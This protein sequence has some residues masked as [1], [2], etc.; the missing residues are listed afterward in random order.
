MATGASA[1]RHAQA[2]FQIA[3]ERDEL[4]IWLD[5]LGQLADAFGDPEFSRVLESPKIRP[6]QKLDLA[7]QRLAGLRTL[8]QNLA[9]L[10][11]TKGRVGI[12]GGIAEEFK[13]LLNDHRGVETA[14]VTTAIKLDEKAENRISGQMSEATGK[15]I[16]LSSN[17]VPEIIGG[18]VIKIGDQL[19][20]GS[21][22]TKLT[23]MRNALAQRRA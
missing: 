22:R 5:D 9:S 17:V 20:D 18:I 4:D 7:R 12:A 14:E 19:I 15:Q 16:T 6:D 13:T 1:R 11:I 3:L 23:A 2:V 8:A 10:L 21:T